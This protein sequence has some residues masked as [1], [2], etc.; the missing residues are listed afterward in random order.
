MAK[1]K[2]WVVAVAVGDKVY[3]VNMDIDDACHYNTA[4]LKI[5]LLDKYGL[6]VN[7]VKWESPEGAT[8]S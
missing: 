4:E 3:F 7:K 1:K 2:D 5:A 8:A 6:Q